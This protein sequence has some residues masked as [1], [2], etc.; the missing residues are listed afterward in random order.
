MGHHATIDAVLKDVAAKLDE[1]A[2]V[3]RQ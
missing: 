3:A 2:A 1:P